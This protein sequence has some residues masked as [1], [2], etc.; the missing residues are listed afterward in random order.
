[1]ELRTYA[2]FLDYRHNEGFKCDRIDWKVGIWPKGKSCMYFE[3]ELVFE[4]KKYKV[5]IDVYFYDQQAERN[6]ENSY[7]FDLFIRTK[8]PDS[9]SKEEE[10]AFAE[11]DSYFQ[12]LSVSFYI[13]LGLQS[14][15]YRYRYSRL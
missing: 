6:C 12:A 9:L 14:K 11:E 7:A 13:L 15:P 4:Q 5:A 1:M 8:H 2:L 10:L 3:R